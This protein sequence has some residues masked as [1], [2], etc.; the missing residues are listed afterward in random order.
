LID[1]SAW[2]SKAKPP[3]GMNGPNPATTSRIARI[4]DML[5]WPFARIVAR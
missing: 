5:R 1:R 3:S 4:S 2:R